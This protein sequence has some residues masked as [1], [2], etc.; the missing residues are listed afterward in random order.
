MFDFSVLVATNNEGKAKEIKQ[1]L[2]KIFSKVLSLVDIGKNIKPEETGKTFYQN[3]LIKATAALSAANNKM[4]VLAD[5][6]GLVVPALKGEPGIMSARYSGI[7]GDDKNNNKLL[8]KKMS[9]LSDRRAYFI[10]V[11]ALIMPDGEIIYSEGKTEGKILTVPKGIGGFGYD[12]LFY[13]YDLGKSFGE[14]SGEEKNQVSHRG[15]AL[16]ALKEK[17][18]G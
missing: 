11:I 16:N 10:C 5:D 17:L 6:S 12:S 13:S 2:G 14:A 4:A 3:A 8:L 1:I 9:N 15:R 7:D 18:Q